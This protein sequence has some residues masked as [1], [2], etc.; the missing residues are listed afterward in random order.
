MVKTLHQEKRTV[1]PQQKLLDFRLGLRKITT[2]VYET[3]MNK[4]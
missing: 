2:D 1:K 3:T 4:K